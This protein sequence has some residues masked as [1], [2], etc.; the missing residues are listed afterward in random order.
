MIK[1]KY[2]YMDKSDLVEY[3]ERLRKR[4][5]KILPMKDDN[6]ATLDEY[7]NHLMVE[8]SGGNEITLKSGLFIEL[9]IN[10]EPLR[11]LDEKKDYK[12]QVFKCT[13]ICKKII[14]KLE[15]G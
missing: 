14:K 8:L 4:I 6:C 13:N 15:G 2:G 1:T 12:P 5:W 3:F 7:L 11:Y 10:L 9:I